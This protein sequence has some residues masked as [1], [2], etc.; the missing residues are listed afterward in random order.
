MDQNE[1]NAPDEQLIYTE[2][3]TRL[4]EIEK[5]LMDM[6]TNLHQEIN[7]RV[8]QRMGEF[9][10]VWA[11]MYGQ[12]AELLNPPPRKETLPTIQ[13]VPAGVGTGVEADDSTCLLTLDSHGEPKLLQMVEGNMQQI[14]LEQ[15]RV[16]N[17]SDLLPHLNEVPIL[18]VNLHKV[19]NRHDG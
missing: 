14:A 18:P 5:R 8:D 2:E 7:R 16:L 3:E 1:Q 17:L 13:L 9:M 15:Y 19:S 10:L 12:Q 4:L 11:R 6:E